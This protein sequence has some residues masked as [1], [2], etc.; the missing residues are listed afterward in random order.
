MSLVLLVTEFWVLVDLGDP[1][2][3]VDALC[4]SGLARQVPF[5]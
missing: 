4:A 2:Q 1:S 3:N 5:D